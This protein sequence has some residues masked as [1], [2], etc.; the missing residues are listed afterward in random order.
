M[1]FQSKYPLKLEK[2]DLH[3][4]NAFYACLPRKLFVQQCNF[5]TS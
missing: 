4:F 1:T 2:Y 3:V 5:A